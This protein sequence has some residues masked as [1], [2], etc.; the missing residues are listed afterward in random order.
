MQTRE[1]ESLSLSRHNAPSRQES[2]EA[3]QADARGAAGAGIRDSLVSALQLDSEVVAK[4]AREEPL[5][6]G[7]AVCEP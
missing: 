3:A 4:E 6:D 2:S 7:A 1:R 5:S